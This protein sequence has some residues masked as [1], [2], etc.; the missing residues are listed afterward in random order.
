MLPNHTFYEHPQKMNPIPLLI[1]G[2]ALLFGTQSAFVDST[3]IQRARPQSPQT[4]NGSGPPPL[5]TPTSVQPRTEYDEFG[6][7]RYGQDRFLGT[8]EWMENQLSVRNAV[9]YERDVEIASLKAR[10][11][12]MVNEKNAEIDRLEELLRSA[13]RL[14]EQ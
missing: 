8:R 6:A 7:S 1:T 10:Y 5:L 4:V 14:N 3:N 12:K 11:T 13:R 2:F 9:I